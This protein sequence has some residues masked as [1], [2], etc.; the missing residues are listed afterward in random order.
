MDRPKSTNSAY[1]LKC[2]WRLLTLRQAHQHLCYY[3]QKC[4]RM[5]HRINWWAFPNH[6]PSTLG[7]KDRMA[8]T[9][10]G[11]ESIS[12]DALPRTAALGGEM[13]WQA[14]CASPHTKAAVVGNSKV[15]TEL[16]NQF[17]KNAKRWVGENEPL[18]GDWG[19]VKVLTNDEH[20][21]RKKSTQMVTFGR[22]NPK[23][24]TGVQINALKN[25]TKWIEDPRIQGQ[26][27]GGGKQPFS[28]RTQRSLAPF[29]SPSHL[30]TAPF[31]ILAA[32]RHDSIWGWICVNMLRCNATMISSQHGNV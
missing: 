8:H 5:C 25:P 21:R 11:G 12:P 10:M 1:V 31:L 32:N 24:H 2:I 28:D 26:G 3:S 18:R 13:Q 9:I 14:N 15:A 29:S 30:S 19:E 17:F 6:R 20:I 7:A 4:S 16:F 23:F 22:I 27:R